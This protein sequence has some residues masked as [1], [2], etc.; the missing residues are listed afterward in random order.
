MPNDIDKDELDDREEALLPVLTDDDEQQTDEDQGDDEQDSAGDDYDIR[1]EM[2]ADD[3][4]HV[5]ALLTDEERAALEDDDGDDDLEDAAAAPE[6]DPT[7][8]GTAPDAADMATKP[9]A[10]FDLTEEELAEIDN[11]AK[12]ARQQARDKWRDG[13]L[14][15][16][17]LDAEMEA[18]GTLREKALQDAM[19]FKQEQVDNEAFETRQADFVEVAR[20]YLT[21]DYPELASKEHILKFD[22]HVR[23]VTA[24]PSY[25]AFSHRQMLEAAHRLYITE[26][27][28]LELK[29]PPIKGKA[30][31][32]PAPTPAKPA[33]R[34]KPEIVP[35]LAR[36]PAAAANTA[37]DGRF[38]TLQARMDAATSP[39]ELEA[40]MRSL[41]AEEREAFA[42]ADA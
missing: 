25:A 29:A 42:S 31:P 28:N 27:E 9:A 33:L 37:S 14:S 26:C 4:A 17:E 10:Q 40:I 6:A 34:S 24:S 36:V 21:T 41:S 23:Q 13:D 8:S 30:K 38:G 3:L 12:A 39:Y 20:A 32:T 19:A 7:G 5:M 35:T 18:A 1:D 22:A 2:S 16:D 15:D 11:Q